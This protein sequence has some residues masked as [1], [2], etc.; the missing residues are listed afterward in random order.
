MFL[1]LAAFVGGLNVA[2]DTTAGERERQH[3]ATGRADAPEDGHAPGP[4][5]GRQRRAA[6]DR[7]QP[8]LPMR[9]GGVDRVGPP[10]GWHRLR[11][12][13]QIGDQLPSRWKT[14]LARRR[15]AE[16]FEG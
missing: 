8:L 14:S 11:L 7:T 3:A 2:I 4:G 13:R 5:P 15:G 10:T 6:L 1:I 9:P 12:L 16:R